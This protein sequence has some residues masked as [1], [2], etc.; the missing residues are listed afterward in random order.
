MMKKKGAVLLTQANDL[1]DGSYSLSLP[2]I[3]WLYL[4]LT[5][6]DSKKPQPE[7]CYTVYAKEYID[8]YDLKEIGYRQVKNVIE[9]L[10]SKPVVIFHYNK[11]KDRVEKDTLYWFSRINQGV[12]DA[13]GDVTVKF[14]EEVRDYLYELK[15]S[16][17]Q[18]NLEEMVKLDSPVAFR[19][20][21]WLMK[22][23]LLNKNKN[24]NGLICTDKLDINWIKMSLGMD[25]LYPKYG[26]FKRRVLEPAVT[27]INNT[28]G[29]TVTYNEIK[30][31]RKVESIVFCY[32][33]EKI[34]D[35]I[36][37]V[38]P[39]MPNRP[40][41][42]KGSSAEGDW[43]RKCIGIMRDYLLRLREYDNNSKLTKPDLEKVISWHKLIGNSFDADFWGLKSNK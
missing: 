42:T 43:A 31:N 13:Y 14:S 9:S 5:K 1:I 10:G 25:G 19:I 17:T 4:I 33:E 11:D 8:V 38:R 26:E 12:G 41:V 37:P 32:I 16:F 40:R 20:Y 28:T 34:I 29:I 24:E 7:G 6:I 22:F 27:I 3:R 23:K 39:R 35:K 15:E 2:E 21:S 30:V 18:I 36:K